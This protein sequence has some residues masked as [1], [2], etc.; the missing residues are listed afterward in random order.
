MN[1]PSDYRTRALIWL[2]IAE[3]SP[4]FKEQAS[5][6]AQDWLT[7]AYLEDMLRRHDSAGTGK[8][9]EANQDGRLA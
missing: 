5:V 6:L 8:N 1:G 4:A 9:D 7:M 3:R 2:E